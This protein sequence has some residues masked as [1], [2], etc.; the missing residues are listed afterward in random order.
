[1]PKVVI[2]DSHTDSHDIEREVLEDAGFDV[3]VVDVS[4][5]EA[6][7]EAGR[8]AD[9]LL[10]CYASVTDEVLDALDDLV[11]VGRQGVGLDNVDVES[12]TE[13]GVQVVHDPE[14]CMDEVPEHA[15]ALILA[16]HRRVARY[17]A[18]LKEGNWDWTIGRPIHRLNGQ[19][20]GIVGFGGIPRKMVERYESFGFELVA[21]DPY[22][23]SEVFEE[24]GVE[25]LGL[26]ALLGRAD[27]VLTQVPLTPDTEGMFDASV[28]ETMQENAIL[29]NTGRGGV[30]DTDDL[31]EAIEADE[32]AGAALDVMPSEPPEEFDLLKHEDVVATPHMAW[33]SEESLN[34]MRRNVTQQVVEAIEG[35]RPEYLANPEVVE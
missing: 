23:D 34:W 30:V 32:I 28:F 3:E 6:V 19:T 13:H 29:V 17:D 18:A 31:L 25:S 10:V 7:I 35:E 26:D 12:A 8:G 15:L 27:I 11:V 5:P 14:Y 2:T 24:Y 1:M 21:H 16:W 22:V 9:G 20:L 4:S 33:Y